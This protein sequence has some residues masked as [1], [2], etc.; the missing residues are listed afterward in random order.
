MRHKELF[1]SPLRT[2]E[3]INIQANAPENVNF[4]KKYF[5]PFKDGAAIWET[6]KPLTKFKA[7]P[8][9]I[10]T[11]Q[12]ISTLFNDRLNIHGVSG[13]G[14]CDCFVS[15]LASIAIANN[16][17][18]QYII[19]GNNKPSHIAI[20]VGDTILDLTNPIPDYLRTYNFT[21]YI[22]PMY[23][24]LADENEEMAMELNENSFD[25]GRPNFRR[26]LNVAKRFNPAAVAV[27]TSAKYSPQ[28]L[29][30]KAIQRQGKRIMMAPQASGIR[31]AS[32]LINRAGG[33]II[34]QMPPAARAKVMLAKRQLKRR[35]FGDSEAE[36]LAI[37]N[38]SEDF[39]RG[40]ISLKRGLQ[41]VG[42]A[43]KAVGRVAMKAAPI[44]LPVAG[45]ALNLIA[46]GVGTKASALLQKGLQRVGGARTLT[47]GRQLVQTLRPSAPSMAIA[48]A[49]VPSIPTAGDVVTMSTQQPPVFSPDTFVTNPVPI[50]APKINPMLI[51]GGGALALLILTRKK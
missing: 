28:A 23:V 42:K 26:A 21:K 31:T 40:R 7:D 4:A 49:V 12:G 11:I 22:N 16:L 3:L 44:L 51:I 25:F 19:Q 47:A 33:G 32:R 43:G 18:Y 35:G 17:P 34:R 37:Q 36:L 9:T 20:K 29:A 1:K 15:A 6:I 10:D 30:L 45:G 39:G 2:V 13:Q 41:N 24:A 27:R 46:P 38:F 8:P 48:P 50:T 5:P 14:D